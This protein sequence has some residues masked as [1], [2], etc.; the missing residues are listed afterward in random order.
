MEAKVI[1]H[2][3]QEYA[4]WFGGSMLATTSQF[5]NICITKQQY[6]EQGS[7]IARNNIAFNARF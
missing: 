7:R 2:N 6:E 1:S 4:V 3:F 5:K